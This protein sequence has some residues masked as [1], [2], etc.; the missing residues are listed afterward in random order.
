MCN[1]FVLIVVG[2]LMHYTHLQL[3]IWYDLFCLVGR[4]L[5]KNRN[6]KSFESY[7]LLIMKSSV[8]LMLL[9]MRKHFIL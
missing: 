4:E 1:K 6:V 3:L 9:E 5:E 2:D 7:R 8:W